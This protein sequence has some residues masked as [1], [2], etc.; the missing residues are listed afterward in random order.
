[1]CN[2]LPIEAIRLNFVGGTITGMD[3]W[4]KFNFKSPN[5]HIEFPATANSV[6][7]VEAIVN[8]IDS[9]KVGTAIEIP[10][11]EALPGLVEEGKK[12]V[13]EAWKNDPTFRAVKA[14]EFIE[15]AQKEL[16]IRAD[17]FSDYDLNY[18][19]KKHKIKIPYALYQASRMRLHAAGLWD[20]SVTKSAAALRG[21]GEEAPER[22]IQVMVQRA[23]TEVFDPPVGQPKKEQI[24]I[25]EAFAALEESVK[26]VIEGHLPSIIVTGPG[27]T[28]KTYTV[29][30]VLKGAGLKESFDYVLV[31]GNITE[32]SLYEALFYYRDKLLVFDDTDAVF[33]NE[34]TA[35][36]L[37]AAL[38]SS[39]VRKISWRTKKTIN[40]ETW[41]KERRDN[42]YGALD[43]EFFGGGDA[44]PE[45]FDIG[46]S[47]DEEPEGENK[48]YEGGDELDDLKLPSSFVFTGRVIFLTNYTKEELVKKGLG[49]VITRSLVVPIEP[50]AEEIFSRLQ[51]IMGTINLVATDGQTVTEPPA[52]MKQE[53]L[54][55]MRKRYEDGYLPVPNIRYFVNV[56]KIRASGNPKWESI[57]RF[58]SGT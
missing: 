44:A 41:T 1:M 36:M 35:N 17:V 31:K 18:V 37:K 32:A 19:S 12:T 26:L 45:G 5:Y 28:G 55:Y 25:N 9:L 20:S 30:S 57:A 33:K 54:A 24:D 50:T 8:E 13:N 53:C 11:G 51:K 23:N 4:N 34:T 6:D 15:I 10:V 40:T 2:G 27:G 21:S 38:D 58:L 42:Y 39:G 46:G 56:L 47:A 7:V 16:G 43:A 52:E 48:G 14:Q 3:V 49:P 22:V 29:S